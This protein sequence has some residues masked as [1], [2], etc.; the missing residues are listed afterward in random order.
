[1]YKFKDK[2]YSE[3]QLTEIAQTNDKRLEH[4]LDLNPLLVQTDPGENPRYCKD[5][6]I[7]SVPETLD[8][9]IWNE[10]KNKISLKTKSTFEYEI[11]NTSRAVGTR[12]SHYF[13]KKFYSFD[14]LL[15][16]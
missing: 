9:K 16:M 10:I 12:L 14:T 5:R 4:L 11:H 2:Q 7:N 13:Y 15:H 6:G 8:E 1:M 3:E